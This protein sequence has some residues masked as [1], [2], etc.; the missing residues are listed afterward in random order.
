MQEQ[1]TEREFIIRALL[2]FEY[3]VKAETA[4]EA[5]QIMNDGELRDK[6]SCTGYSVDAVV[7]ADKAGHFWRDEDDLRAR[8][9]C[10][11]LVVN[12]HTG[13]RFGEREPSKSHP[14]ACS[15]YGCDCLAPVEAVA[16]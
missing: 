10:G 4:D 5:E 9:T 16:A 13:L 15:S 1:S 3:R 6:G 14:Q 2:E 7:S 8:C 11:H 12:Q